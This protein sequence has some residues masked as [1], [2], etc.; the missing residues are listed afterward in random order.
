VPSDRRHL[1]IVRPRRSIASGKIVYTAVV[2]IV[3][4]AIVWLLFVSLVDTSS[5]DRTNTPDGNAQ[6]TQRSE[7]P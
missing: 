4:I 6:P 5:N 1:R 7:S 2:C 3:W